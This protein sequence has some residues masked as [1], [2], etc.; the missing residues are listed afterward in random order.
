MYLEAES[1]IDPEKAKFHED[2]P[3]EL[4]LYPNYIAPAR[5]T[6]INENGELLIQFEASTVAFWTEPYS[7]FIHPCGYW[8]YLKTYKYDMPNS[9]AIKKM[10]FEFDKFRDIQDFTVEEGCKIY[11]EDNEFSWKLFFEINQNVLIAS[12]NTFNPVQLNDMTLDHYPNY[13]PKTK[14]LLSCNFKYNPRYTWSSLTH[15]NMEDFTDFFRE[16][17][18]I[19]LRDENTEGLSKVTASSLVLMPKKIDK[20]FVYYPNIRSLR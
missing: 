16:A 12:F 20:D 5:I 11:L 13:V 8:N 10:M 9:K 17:G 14:N 7:R 15:L 6:D 19:K 1:K 3:N 2:D 4:D 18:I